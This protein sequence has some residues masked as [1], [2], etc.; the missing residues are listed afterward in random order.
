MLLFDVPAALRRLRRAFR[1]LPLPGSRAAAAP[2]SPHGAGDSRQVLLLTAWHMPSVLA[3]VRLLLPFR[4]LERRSCWQ[5]AGF[6]RS[7]RWLSR[8]SLLLTSWWADADSA[9]RWVRSDAFRRFDSSAGALGARSWVELREHPA[10]AQ[11][12]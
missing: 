2:P 3:T 8:R 11:T 10:R 1:P 7:H 4:R 6:A 9:Q 12:P 5:A